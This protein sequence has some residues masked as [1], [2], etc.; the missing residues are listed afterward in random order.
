M[1]AIDSLLEL[2]FRRET[3]ATQ[4]QSRR[5]AAAMVGVYDEIR[6]QFF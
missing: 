6:Q 4:A 2:G 5:I 1:P 3:I